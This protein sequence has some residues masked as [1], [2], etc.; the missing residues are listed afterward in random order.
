LIGEEIIEPHD[1]GG[2]PAWH[3]PGKGYDFF[4][5][6]RAGSRDT[7][8]A[9]EGPLRGRAC[10]VNEPAP[11]TIE[12]AERIPMRAPIE[13]VHHGL[14]R[15]RVELERKSRE[16]A[17]ERRWIAAHAEVT[18]AVR[19]KTPL[20]QLDVNQRLRVPLWDV[21]RLHARATQPNVRW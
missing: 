9:S 1:T 11:L 4:M 2:L 7:P 10:F 19:N 20:H 14:T 8:K 3:L 15:I 5:A 21:P 16:T 17:R 12:S 18:Q 13:V 6:F